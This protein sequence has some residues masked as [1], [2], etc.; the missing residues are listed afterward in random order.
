MYKRQINVLKA[1]G[2]P[3]KIVK[4]VEITM[5][6]AKGKVSLGREKSKEFTITAGV[7]Q[8]DALSVIL[9]NLALQYV[10]GK[11]LVRGHIFQR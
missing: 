3:Q 5:D 11:L 9:F 10:A 8:G 2:I 1:L 7:K 6:G 4:L